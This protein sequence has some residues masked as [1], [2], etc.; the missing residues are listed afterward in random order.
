VPAVQSGPLVPLSLAGVRWWHIGLSVA[1]LGLLLGETLV[2]S[3][4]FDTNIPVFA[5]HP[6]A[7]VRLISRSSILLRI[8]ICLVTVATMVLLGS[9]GLRRDLRSLMDH[10]PYHARY[11][12][13]IH[14][15][16]YGTFFWLT[17]RLIKD[18]AQS[19][20]PV[21]ATI[22]WMACGAGTLV[23]WGLAA[24]P[25]AFWLGVLRRTWKVLV[26]GAVV[27]IVAVE[28]GGK[29]GRLWGVFHR[30]TFDAAS[31]V[32]GWLDPNVI[33][34]PENLVLGV[35]GFSVSIAPVCSGFEGI[36][37]IWAFLGGYLVLF[38]RDLRFPQALLLIPIGTMIIWLFNVM[39]I[40]VLVLVGAWGRPEVALGGFH[41]QAGWLAFNIVGL[42]LVAVSRWVGWFS[43]VDA[44]EPSPMATRNPT[45]AYL[46]PFLAIVATAMVTG[47]MSDG[48]FDRL[49]SARIIAAVAVLIVFRQAYA[50]WRWSWSWS[51]LAVGA[52]VFFIWIALVPASGSDEKGSGITLARNLAE[53]PAWGAACWLA[54]RTF[55]SVV[56]VPLAEELAF[57]GYLVRRLISANFETVSGANLTWPALIVSSV[58]FGA[59]HQ[60]W[61]AGTIAGMLYG[62]VFRHDG[63]LGHAVLCHATTNAMIAA[64]VLISGAWSLWA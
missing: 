15:G 23:T 12:V 30:W 43:K 31:T 45:A 36:G 16:A 8:A 47:A 61:V 29:T 7:V 21:F 10:G 53:M 48:Q 5:D 24:K 46:G 28:I 50:G 63:Q 51:A 55:G 13:A 17:K 9:A 6:S 44:P 38:R 33:C 4:C 2:L 62:L 60:R 22:L 32:L 40:V 56:I 20:H 19:T 35:R 27:G 11:W 18:L 25:P 42:G 3:L 14:L 34:H 49:Y 64:C 58:L 41:S 52:I 39:R 37:L 57:R 26:A 54:A 1:W 59:I